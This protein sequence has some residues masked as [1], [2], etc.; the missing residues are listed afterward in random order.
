MTMDPAM[1]NDMRTPSIVADKPA[2]DA[3]GKRFAFFDVDETV[4]RFK[5]MFVFANHYY[6][7][8]GP[9]PGVIGPLRHRAFMARMNGY[10]RAGRS[11][12]FINMAYY[13]EFAGRSQAAV[14]RLVRDW[15]RELRESGQDIYFPA[16]LEVIRRHQAANTRVV[17]VSGSFTELLEPIAEELNVFKVL[18][19]RLK[20]ENGRYT[21]AILPQQMIGAGKAAAVRLLLEDEGADRADSW[22][23]GDHHSDIPMLSEVGHPTIVSRDPEMIRL[24]AERQW[25][26]L[27]PLLT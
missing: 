23:Y 13:R 17:L 4:I 3:S 27:D 16:V 26:V 5:S 22:A 21:G 18:A 2:L 7:R 11:R 8:T 24:A 14:Q 6:N 25:D 19:T 10:L 20:V 12:E 15:F 1:P 9:L